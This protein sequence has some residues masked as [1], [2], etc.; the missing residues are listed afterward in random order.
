MC[1]HY[2]IPCQIT[3]LYER[4]FLNCLEFLDLSW[5]P[6]KTYYIY[7]ACRPPAYL[8]AMRLLL[9]CRLQQHLI[10]ELLIVDFYILS[11]FVFSRHFT[12][13]VY[14]LLKDSQSDLRIK[15]GEVCG[16]YI[17]DITSFSLAGSRTLLL[18]VSD[19]Y[20]VRPALVGLSNPWYDLW[21]IP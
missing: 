4:P 9:K 2:H 14:R 11:R 19:D 12:V 15:S 16:R 21:N 13:D 3:H 18:V 10:C 7:E 6:P 17:N 8:T 20:A 5:L 1:I